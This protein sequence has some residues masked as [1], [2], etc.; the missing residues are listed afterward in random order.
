[1]PIR[2]D[3]APGESAGLIYESGVG[4]TLTVCRRGRSRITPDAIVDLCNIPHSCALSRRAASSCAVVVDFPTPS[5]ALKIPRR[6]STSD[7]PICL[8]AAIGSPMT[9][10]SGRPN[11]HTVLSIPVAQVA[12]RP[13]MAVPPA[14]VSLAIPAEMAIEF[15]LAG[16]PRALVRH[17]W[18]RM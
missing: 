12:S 16:R 1:V 17:R 5:D 15:E 13:R 14:R 11:V 9:K 18:R 2:R 8:T 10:L 4:R 7:S 3:A 6:P